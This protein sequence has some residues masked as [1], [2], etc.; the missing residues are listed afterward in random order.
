MLASFSCLLKGWWSH[1]SEHFSYHSRRTRRSRWSSW[2]CRTLMGKANTHAHYSSLTHWYITIST[3]HTCTVKRAVNLQGGR[4]VQVVPE[5]P[6][7]RDH[8]GKVTDWPLEISRVTLTDIYTPA[9]GLKAQSIDV[10]STLY[11][12]RLGV[13]I[14]SKNTYLMSRSAWWSRWTW[15]SSFT[16]KGWEWNASLFS[17]KS[18]ACVMTVFIIISLIQ[19]LGLMHKQQTAT[20]SRQTDRRSVIVKRWVVG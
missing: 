18:Q 9:L 15:R 2:T 10:L 5:L 1:V 12:N 4:G 20:V 14:E 16:L 6:G 3:D 8:P 7:C 13:M 17:T 19:Q 11:P